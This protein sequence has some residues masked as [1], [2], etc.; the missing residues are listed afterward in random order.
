[1]VNAQLIDCVG[2]R[3]E[4]EQIERDYLDKL[5]EVLGSEEALREAYDAHEALFEKYESWPP[6]GVIDP[7]EQAAWDRFENA[8]T[9]AFYFAFRHWKTP[10]EAAYFALHFWQGPK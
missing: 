6:D 10:P 2:A 1:M 8:D 3:L 5:I 4:S 7:A 9:T